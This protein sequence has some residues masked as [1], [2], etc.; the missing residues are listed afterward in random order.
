MKVIAW[1]QSVNLSSKAHKDVF[2]SVTCDRYDGNEIAC[3]L[4]RFIGHDEV[5]NGSYQHKQLETKLRDIIPSYK[6]LE[7]NFRIGFN[8]EERKASDIAPVTGSTEGLV[9]QILNLCIL[10]DYW[11][12]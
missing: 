7:G 3:L 10:L 1:S 12:C 8:C 2:N 5:Y 9:V 6:T 4:I 11:Q